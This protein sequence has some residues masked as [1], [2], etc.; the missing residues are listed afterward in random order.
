MSSLLVMLTELDD[1]VYETL[2]RD[3]YF[4]VVGCA[5]FLLL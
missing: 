1:Y 2:L 4:A 3:E 5:L